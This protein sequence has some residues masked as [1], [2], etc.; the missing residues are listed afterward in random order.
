MFLPNC[1]YAPFFVILY[2]PRFSSCFFVLSV[3][4]YAL[5]FWCM[6]NIGASEAFRLVK[7]ISQLPEP[8]NRF[9]IAFFPYSRAK[10][11]ASATLTVKE[12]CTFRKQLPK[13]QFSVDSDNF[14]LYTDQDGNPR[15]CYRVLVRFIGFPQDNYKL[16]KVKSV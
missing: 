15:S 10:G 1:I 8:D 7:E 6:K 2:M 16:K 11:E 9:K 14:F 12:N 4:L 3:H 13:D 5:Y